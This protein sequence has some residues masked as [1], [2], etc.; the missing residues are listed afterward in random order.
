[1][2]LLPSRAFEHEL[3]TELLHASLLF[4]FE[5]HGWVSNQSDPIPSSIGIQTCREKCSQ[6]FKSTKGEHMGSIR[7]KKDSLNPNSREI[8]NLFGTSFDSIL[9]E[10]PFLYNDEEGIW[11]GANVFGWLK[12]SLKTSSFEVWFWI[13]FSFYFFTHSLILFRSFLFSFILFHSLIF[14]H[15]FHSLHSLHSLSFFPFSH[16]KSLFT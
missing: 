2:D 12:K 13:F 1:M 8:S 15:Y 5:I 7:V 4:G 3:E 16:F 11:K 14:S 6:T 10:S 9:P